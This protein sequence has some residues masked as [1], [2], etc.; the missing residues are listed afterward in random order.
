MNT[1]TYPRTFSWEQVHESKPWY[2]KTGRLEFY[3]GEPEFL[4]AGENL[5]VYREPVDST[6]YD[7]NVH[8]G[9]AAPG[10][11][12]EDAR[13]LWLRPQQARLVGAAGAQRGR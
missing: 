9:P 4:E 10:D 13:G 3:R 8:R 12:A 7:P 2:T 5:V 1:R 6:F 11:P